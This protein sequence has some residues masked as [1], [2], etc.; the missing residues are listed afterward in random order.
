MLPQGPVTVR[1]LPEPRELTFHLDDVVHRGIETARLTFQQN[2]DRVD[3]YLGRFQQFGK[4]F[5]RHFKLQPDTFVQ[6]AMHYAY[7]RMY[8]R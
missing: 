8:G 1:D 2:G 3:L 4:T 6:M 5:I 7:Y